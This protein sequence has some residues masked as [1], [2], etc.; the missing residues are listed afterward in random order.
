MQVRIARY[1]RH[2]MFSAVIV[3]TLGLVITTGGFPTVVRLGDAALEFYSRAIS[4]WGQHLME[5]LDP[6]YPRCF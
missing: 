4:D 2:I 1:G 6:T 3:S 5:K